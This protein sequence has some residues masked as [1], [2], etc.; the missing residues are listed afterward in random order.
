MRKDEADGATEQRMKE[1]AKKLTR[2]E[3]KTERKT[4]TK[5][6]RKM[7]MKSERLT[8]TPLAKK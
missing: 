3:T 4:R 6:K 7:K 1:W 2:T 8:R 5:M